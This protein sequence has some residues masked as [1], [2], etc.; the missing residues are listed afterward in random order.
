MTGRELKALRSRSGLGAAKFGAALGYGG[1][2]HTIARMVRRMEGTDEAV[3]ER[4]S[5]LAECFERKLERIER[6]WL[7]ALTDGKTS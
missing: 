3:P 7:T 5:F 6:K 2:S 4:V 1:K